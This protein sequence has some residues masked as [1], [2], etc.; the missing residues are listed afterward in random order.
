MCDMINPM[1]LVAACTEA[2][3]VVG[4]ILTPAGC[5]SAQNRRL[6]GHIIRF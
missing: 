1:I 2:S 6:F 4:G 5:P 3:Q